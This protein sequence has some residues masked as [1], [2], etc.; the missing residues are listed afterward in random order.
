MVIFALH[1][2]GRPVEVPNKAITYRVEA[3]IGEAKPLGKRSELQDPG[4]RSHILQR[5]GY[6][7]INPDVHQVDRQ[8]GDR[9]EQ[10]QGHHH[11]RYLLPDLQPGGW[12]RSV[13]G[14]A[15]LHLA[16]AAPQPAHGEEADDH[17]EQDWQAIEGTEE[18][19]VVGLFEP[20]L[21]PDLPADRKNQ[22]QALH[23]PNLIPFVHEDEG[24]AYP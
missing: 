14:S 5:F 4:R 11:L 7:E 9:E 2:L 19:K 1:F 13:Q 24:H 12:Q 18:Q 15:L 21:R 20:L 23:H 16:A 3:G 22:R 6:V 8:P 17:V 10:D